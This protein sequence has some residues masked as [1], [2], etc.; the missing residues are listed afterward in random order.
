[1]KQCCT[2]R[3]A[4]DDSLARER[5]MLTTY[6]HSGYVILIAFPLQQWLHE[7][8]SVLGYTYIACLAFFSSF[9]RT[10][11]RLKAVFVDVLS[12]TFRREISLLRETVG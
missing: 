6:R 8:V 7:R 3:Q 4:T 9:L 10:E 2:V 12:I 1:M 5:R 11:T